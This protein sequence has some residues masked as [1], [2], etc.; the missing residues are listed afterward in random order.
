M[1]LF[2]NFDFGKTQPYEALKSQENGSMVKRNY[3]TKEL[4]EQHKR[5]Q[6]YHFEYINKNTL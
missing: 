3:E 1:T 2:E 5:N 6:L 4:L